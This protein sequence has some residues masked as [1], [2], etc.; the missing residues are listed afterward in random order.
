MGAVR[1]VSEAGGGGSDLIGKVLPGG[2]PGGATI[3]A[4][5][6]VLLAAILKKISRGYMLASYDR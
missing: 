6:W 4:E 5:T 1:E 2:G 3:G